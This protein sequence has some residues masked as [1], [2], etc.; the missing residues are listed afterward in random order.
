MKTENKTAIILGAT[1]LTGGY[2]LNALLAD[3]RYSRV[4]LFSRSS[5]GIRHEKLK[6]ILVDMFHLERYKNEFY[7]DEV[8]C[9]VGTTKAK[10][11]DKEQYKE[12]DYGIPVTV[13][14]ICKEQQIP[15]LLIIS[16]LGANP[17]SSLF[18]SRL[19]GVMEKDVEEEQLEK[20]HFLQPSLISGKRK[21]F[22]LGEWFMKQ[23]M[24]ILNL[25][26]V[27]PL[28]KYKSIH[29]KDIATAMIWLANNPYEKKRIPSDILKKLARESA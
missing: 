2:V 29:P 3:D 11:P 9:C 1:G 5:V 10:T 26:L 12:I 25:V 13:A 16:A 6:E 8:F 23:L 21:E 18:Y 14:R 19:K 24:K 4:I 7:A 22:R 15:S 28:D 20:V 27:G 17:N